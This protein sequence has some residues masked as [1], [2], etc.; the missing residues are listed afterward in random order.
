[1]PSIVIGSGISIGPG[2][3]VISDNTVGQQAYTTAGTYSW[4]APAGVTSV[5]VV[6]VGGGGGGSRGNT[7]G[8][9]GDSYFIDNTT[10]AG[11]GGLRGGANSG[12]VEIGRAHV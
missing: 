10:V 1:M 12:T 5:C 4:T 7:A 9:G 2:I 6:C 3:T 8:N 11:F